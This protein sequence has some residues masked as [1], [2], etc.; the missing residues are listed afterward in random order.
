M[1]RRKKKHRL[2]EPV[3]TGDAL[4]SI[5]EEDPD[6]LKLVGDIMESNARQL[7][8]NF[9]M[10]LEGE[11]RAHEQT[12]GELRRAEN[13]LRDIKERIIWLLGGD[14]PGSL[15]FEIESVVE[16]EVSEAEMRR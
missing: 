12:K 11:Q 14:I 7:D 10:Q 8:A 3:T 6:A 4:V 15:R 2:V 16:D 5:A 1:R 9:A 13:E